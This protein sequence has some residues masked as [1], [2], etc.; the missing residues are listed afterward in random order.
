MTLTTLPKSTAPPLATLVIF[1]V[2]SYCTLAQAG[3]ANLE[4]IE[5][6]F[7]DRFDAS[8]TM[9]RFDPLLTNVPETLYNVITLPLDVLSTLPDA[10]D[11]V[12][13]IMLPAHTAADAEVFKTVT[14]IGRQVS[15][16]LF[17]PT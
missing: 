10:P 11:A 1:A 6:T 2:H 14:T 7:I 16:I 12:C 4:E 9:L 8:R 15:T 13:V 5:V 3:S 17:P